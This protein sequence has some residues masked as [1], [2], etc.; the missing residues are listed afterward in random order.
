ME[1]SYGGFWRRAFAFLIDT[2]ILYLIFA[3]FFVMG[4]VV[5]GLSSSFAYGDFSLRRLTGMTIIYLVMYHLTIAVI[6]MLYFTY[7][8]GTVGQTP[9]KMIFGLKVIQSN[10]RELNLGI[11]FLRWV[12]Y[13]VSAL[14]LHLGFIWIAFDSKKRGWHD[15][16]AKTI[17]VRLRGAVTAPAP[18][19]APAPTNQKYLDKEGELL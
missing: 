14:V 10:G 3:L 18:A 9:G 13:I 12:G 15:M 16:I 17:V 19:P 6:G 4:I 2:V 11:G 7:F 8:H 1:Y 5:L